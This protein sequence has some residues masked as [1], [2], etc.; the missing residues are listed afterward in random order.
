LHPPQPGFLYGRVASMSEHEKFQ[1]NYGWTSKREMVICARGSDCRH[2]RGSRNGDL[3]AL[4]RRYEFLTGASKKPRAVWLHRGSAL[5]QPTSSV[6]KSVYSIGRSLECALGTRHIMCIVE[7]RLQ[8]AITCPNCLQPNAFKF[9]C[10]ESREAVRCLG[11]P[12]S[13]YRLQGS[14]WQRKVGLSLAAETQGRSRLRV[15]HGA[16]GIR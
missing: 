14:N 16:E 15:M 6:K 2:Q 11:A 7:L 5:P 3:L 4:G 1:I 10:H 8:S 13:R 9:Y 12:K